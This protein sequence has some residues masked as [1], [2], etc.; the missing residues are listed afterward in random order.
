MKRRSRPISRS[1]HILNCIRRMRRCSRS[2]Y[3]RRMRFTSRA[4]WSGSFDIA[5]SKEG[6]ND[7][8]GTECGDQ[9]TVDGSGADRRCVERT[10]EGHA[11][12]V[13]AGENRFTDGAVLEESDE[14]LAGE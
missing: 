4:Y 3:S 14:P 6:G 8:D 10:V 9:R 5:Q 7:D 2:S 11:V 13:T 1:R 12:G